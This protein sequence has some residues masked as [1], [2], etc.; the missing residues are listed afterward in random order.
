MNLLLDTHTLIWLLNGDSQLSSTALTA[1]QDPT[2]EVCI[3]HAAVWEIAIKNCLGKLELHRPF[4][5]LQKQLEENG[6]DF[7]PLTFDHFLTVN[8]LPLYHRDPFDRLMISQ[9]F[10]NQLTVVTKD[11]LFQLYSVPLLW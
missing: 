9:A 3:S 8:R 11:P 4:H 2:N 5:E 7:L 1:I 10:C 6:L